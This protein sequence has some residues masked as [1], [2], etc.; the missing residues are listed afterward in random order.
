[1]TDWGSPGGWDKNYTTQ[2]DHPLVRA[3]ER[4]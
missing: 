2:R 1:V 4:A 3:Y